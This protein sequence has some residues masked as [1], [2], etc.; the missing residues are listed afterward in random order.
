MEFENRQFSGLSK[1][2][3]AFV[4]VAALASLMLASAGPA[5]AKRMSGT[6]GAD[7]IVGTAKA[8]VI[9]GRARQRPHQ[10]PRRQGSS[11]GGGGSEGAAPTA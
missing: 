1:R 2:V 7:R 3:I 5:Q 4:G 10:G 8:D 11:P 9:K 6:A